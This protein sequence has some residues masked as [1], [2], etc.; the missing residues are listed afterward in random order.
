MSIG[1]STLASP[2]T[3][4][5]P[6]V[7]ATARREASRPSIT[8]QTVSHVALGHTNSGAHHNLR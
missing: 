3:A 1:Q 8:V 6:G 4:T 2:A 5:R 7:V